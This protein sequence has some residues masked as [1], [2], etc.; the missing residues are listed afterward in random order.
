LAR[1]NDHSNAKR[2][3]N[4]DN[5]LGQL[6]D[7]TISSQLESKM[8]GYHN[9]NQHS[10]GGNSRPNTNSNMQA[11]P[12]VQQGYL[13]G[14]ADNSMM[15]P[16]STTNMPFS[17][18]AG[19]GSFPPPQ[20]HTQPQAFQ[21]ASF[22][23]AQFMFSPPSYTTTTNNN[24]S[25]S[26]NSS[27][28]SSRGGAGGNAGQQQ[29]QQKIQHQVSDNTN[30]S[31]KQSHQE[32]TS[33]LSSNG[34]K[35]RPMYQQQQQSME[36]M[37]LNN[38]TSFTMP[39]Q[40]HEDFL[41]AMNAAVQAQNAIQTQP[42]QQQGI[43]QSPP[44]YQ[45]SS[46]YGN[47]NIGIPNTA[48]GSNNGAP[49]TQ[50][51][52]QQMAPTFGAFCMDPNTLA[53]LQQ[54]Q[55]QNNLLHQQQQQPAVNKP[56]SAP[57]PVPLLPASALEQDPSLS[58]K[59]NSKPRNM[60]AK[61][62]TF[63]SKPN[64]SSKVSSKASAGAKKRASTNSKR[65]AAAVASA[66][67]SV[68]AASTCDGEYCSD[69]GDDYDCED[70]LHMP[71][72]SASVD[73]TTDEKAR[74]NR[75][76]NREH[77]RSTRARK[78]AYVSKLK[79]LVEGLHAQRADEARKRRFATQRLAEVQGVRRTVVRSFLTGL[80]T[81]E[82]S[83]RKWATWI[84]ENDFWLKQP[85][86]PFRYFCRNETEASAGGGGDH[87]ISRGISAIISEAA[88]LAV[89]IDGIGSR[90]PRWM[91]I[92]RENY[93]LRT[94]GEAALLE[95]N[96]AD[97]RK[98]AEKQSAGGDSSGTC[99]KSC[100]MPSSVGV[101]SDR[102]QHA[103]SSLSS[104]SSGGGGHNSSSSRSSG[105]G[106]EEERQKSAAILSLKRKRGVAAAAESSAALLQERSNGAL[107][108][109]KKHSSPSKGQP[110]TGKQSPE[111]L[112]NTAQG[113][114][115]AITTANDESAESG[116]ASKPS[117]SD[118]SGS[119][120]AKV[121]SASSSG[122]AS[123]GPPAAMSSSGGSG[124][125]KERSPNTEF[126]D[127]NAPSLPDE[128]PDGSDADGSVSSPTGDDSGNSSND[129]GA[130][131]DRESGTG[132]SSEQ[133]SR[134]DSSSSQEDEQ[135][136][137][138]DPGN[139]KDDMLHRHHHH[140]QKRARSSVAPGSVC[141]DSATTDAVKDGK[142]PSNS[143]TSNNSTSM[144]MSV[145]HVLI[146]Q[147]SQVPSN[148]TTC[149]PGS[150]SIASSEN[151]S[152]GRTKLAE[153][154]AITLPP[155]MGI[156]KRPQGYD[157]SAPTAVTSATKS[158]S[159]TVMTSLKAPQMVV[160][161]TNLEI[162]TT[163]SAGNAEDCSK[164]Q[165]GASQQDTASCSVISSSQAAQS[166]LPQIR[167]YFHI[168]EDDMLITDDVMMCPFLFRSQDAVICGAL[169]EVNMPGMLRA[170]FSARNKLNH[171]EMIYDAMGF[172]QQ[173]E[174]ASG[175]E[176]IAQVVPNSLEM[177]LSPNRNE[178][179]AISMAQAPYPLICVNEAF[180]KLTKYTQMEAEGKELTKLLRGPKTID[181]EHACRPP[182]NFATVASGICACTVVVHYDK[183]GRDFLNYIC[184]YPLKNLH[185]EVT[186]LLHI[187]KE[188]TAPEQ[189][190]QASSQY[191]FQNT[192][193][194]FQ[195]KI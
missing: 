29:T 143:G 32:T 26:N 70:N 147:A 16:T 193:I 128:L 40:S 167:G 162:A 52:Q 95:Q 138:Q 13:M 8:E 76:R 134:M 159:E 2:V 14:G 175:S 43:N 160:S 96:A 47:V 195:Q 21:Q 12:P 149:A 165:D 24:N 108:K 112:A 102:L 129:G 119:G 186:H 9:N 130:V 169:S 22:A 177:A 10:N 189:I 41:N 42:Q 194:S 132:G 88:S 87:R 120:A 28:G 23:P 106:S 180:T 144:D 46:P 181:L 15:F 104:S 158:S 133:S 84:E 166:N 155:F 33:S 93:L 71:N 141:S 25:N 65:P 107:K 78:K 101:A 63:Q 184:S 72:S 80:A 151:S 179:R 168:N 135:E 191:F 85:V 187:C 55:H 64:S 86:T 62:A 164:S 60:N 58:A 152:N 49:Q 69:S 157:A 50:N 77:A 30:N 73:M 139:L 172:M 1:Y 51:Q 145:Q 174:R 146:P 190:P 82:S 117:S 89:M 125:S 18:A 53:M 11:P 188:L 115:T 45:L 185:G 192:S 100:H 3:E 113:V 34:T 114:A 17:A 37:R 126:H 131:A 97:A 19:W 171:V 111:T 153:V 94:G 91:H 5:E 163:R 6:K 109:S 90:N 123:Q 161:N 156:G 148:I 182:H 154:P 4:Q 103:M 56:S 7:S 178:A 173:L 38:N 44:F 124:S 68:V 39:H 122:I 74:Q 83:K 61:K 36:I 79:E 136:I 116:E 59:G 170:S 110:V 81:F 67:N 140:R 75:E 142:K 118:P 99:S 127:Y 27:D 31:S 35:Q 150:R 183:N 98:A 137:K 48:Y 20:Q 57:V 105:S 176:G 92:K 54:Q 66:N 121:V